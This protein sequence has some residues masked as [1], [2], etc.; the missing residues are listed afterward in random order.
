MGVLGGAPPAEVV[1]ARRER[2]ALVRRVVRRD[3]TVQPWEMA[4]K[5]AAVRA[6]EEEWVRSVLRGLECVVSGVRAEM[7]PRV[8][9]EE[10]PVPVSDV[11]E[12]VDEE[13]EEVIEVV[14]HRVLERE[15]EDAAEEELPVPP[16]EEWRFVWLPSSSSLDDDS[17]DE[18]DADGYESG[19]E[20]EDNSEPEYCGSDYDDDEVPSLLRDTH[21]ASSSEAADSPLVP[22]GEWALTVRCGWEWEKRVLSPVVVGVAGELV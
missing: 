4:E 20:S 17:E 2:D 7:G 21:S 3:Q 1:A 19:D 8:K 18:S 11:L 13:E 9:E 16:A 14:G 12:E 15:D 10:V 22:C 5:E 6:A